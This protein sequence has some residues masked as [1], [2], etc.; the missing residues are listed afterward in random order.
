VGILMIKGLSLKQPYPELIISGRKTTEL[1]K[2]NTRFRGEFLV[3]ASKA[4]YKDAC[5]HHNID[6]SSLITR[7]IIGS[8]VLY[9]VKL[10]QSQTEFDGL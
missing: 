4:V 8:A 1:R 2:W 6:V 5:G 7:A 3:H 9:D 10:S